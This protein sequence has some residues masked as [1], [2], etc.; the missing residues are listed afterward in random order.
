MKFTCCPHG[1]SPFK[2][3]VLAE[4][5]QLVMNATNIPFPS[6]TV[7]DTIPLSQPRLKF[8][9][10]N[11]NKLPALSDQEVAESL[12]IQVQSFMSYLNEDFCILN[13][14]EQFLARIVTELYFSIKLGKDQLVDEKSLPNFYPQLQELYQLYE[15]L[16]RDPLDFKNFSFLLALSFLLTAMQGF[17]EN[18]QVISDGVRAGL[19]LLLS[20][21]E[22]DFVSRA[23][24]LILPP[25][26]LST[27]FLKTMAHEFVI[28]EQIASEDASA[29]PSVR[30]MA[31][32]LKTKYGKL[33][34][35]D[36]SEELFATYNTFDY[37]ECARLLWDNGTGP[38]ETV[39]LGFGR[40]FLIKMVKLQWGI[41]REG[42]VYAPDRS[43][44]LLLMDDSKVDFM[45]YSAK[46]YGRL[47]SLIE[48]LDRLFINNGMAGPILELSA[49]TMNLVYQD[50]NEYLE[51]LSTALIDTYPIEMQSGITV[52]DYKSRISIMRGAKLSI[53][54]GAY[55]LALLKKILIGPLNRF[56]LGPISPIVERF[57]SSCDFSFLYPLTVLP[58]HFKAS[59][60]TVE[61]PIYESY[62]FLMSL[63]DRIKRTL[64]GSQVDYEEEAPSNIKAILSIIVSSIVFF[65][66]GGFS[67]WNIVNDDF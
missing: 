27:L 35:V 30:M 14:D 38:D 11:G 5:L 23:C 56:N 47:F 67:L 65:V 40:T 46:M 54:L 64:N 63:D 20:S 28:L 59:I 39:L 44:N 41:I 60:S 17:G 29:K 36:L 57:V 18:D 66:A 51:S 34:T 37:D 32:I 9:D 10:R 48:A 62:Q 6:S 53:L 52:I 43:S 8:Y 22:P 25:P 12:H 31:D 55:N 15:K 4:P 45:E 49:D 24:Q 13:Y 16:L 21:V 33:F 50:M 1:L 19:T 58:A 61:R 3:T 26:Q 42:K 7:E 2:E